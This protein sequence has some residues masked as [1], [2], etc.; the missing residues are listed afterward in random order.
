MHAT[1]S[2]GPHPA[3]WMKYILMLEHG[4]RG[5]IDEKSLPEPSR[6][7][8]NRDA[9]IAQYWWL[10]R[11]SYLL[12]RHLGLATRTQLWT[13][14]IISYRSLILD[15]STYCTASVFN[16]YSF[17]HPRFLSLSTLQVS[18]LNLNTGTNLNCHTINSLFSIGSSN[19]QC[20]REMKS[21]SIWELW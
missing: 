13:Y 3:S 11:T 20:E 7:Q 16:D 14:C 8:D 4:I 21:V 12:Y 2:D 9:F 6:I 15:F 19:Y 1:H 18:H 5:G 10:L 17:L